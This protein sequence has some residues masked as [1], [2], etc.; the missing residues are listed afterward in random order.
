MG[1]AIKMPIKDVPVQL[2]SSAEVKKNGGGEKSC[3][4]VT[5]MTTV[6]SLISIPL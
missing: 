5:D 2:P 1:M 4:V 3:A 6:L